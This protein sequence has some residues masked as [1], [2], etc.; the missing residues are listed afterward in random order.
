[1][2]G[3]RLSE[4][5]LGVFSSM[6]FAKAGTLSLWRNYFFPTRIAGPWPTL[7]LEIGELVRSP[8]I[9]VTVGVC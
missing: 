5:N 1:M 8:G 7:K 9:G 2:F 6:H 3:N 4:Q